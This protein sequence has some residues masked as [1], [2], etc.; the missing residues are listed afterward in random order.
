MKQKLVRA[1]R[2]RVGPVWKLVDDAGKVWAEIPQID[3]DGRA[4]TKAEALA[5][6]EAFDEWI[7]D[8]K[9]K[10]QSDDDDAKPI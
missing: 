4:I 2:H 3:L 5:E 7:E 9:R 1:S 8:N 6:V 10:G